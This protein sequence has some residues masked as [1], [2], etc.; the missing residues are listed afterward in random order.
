LN[1]ILH[2]IEKTN[3]LCS[4]GILIAEHDIIEHILLPKGFSTLTSLTFGKT[5]VDIIQKD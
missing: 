1:K 5:I 3:S 2:E 4:Q